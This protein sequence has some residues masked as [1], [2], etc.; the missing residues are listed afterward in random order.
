MRHWRRPVFVVEDHVNNKSDM[1]VLTQ[2]G[3]D[4]IKFPEVYARDRWVQERAESLPAGSKVLDAGAGASKYRSLFKHCQYKTQD[5]CQYKGELVKYLQP[6][7]YVCDITAIPLPDASLDVILCTEV[8]EHVV[9]PIK[10]LKEFQRLLKPG[11]RLWLTAPMLSH[12][13]MEPYHYFSGFTHYWY[14]HWLPERGFKIESLERVGGPGRSF[15]AFAEAFYASWS[16]REKQSKGAGRWVSFCMRMPVKV[17]VHYVLPRL[18]PRMDTW[19]GN[20]C[21]Y[22]SVLVEARRVTA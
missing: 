21:I 14:E 11:G 17:L 6:I 16:A 22:S 19:L 10:V 15:V 5:F 13:H 3:S 18:V 12:I 1:D 20:N 9:D 4:R 2:E 8:L 7:D